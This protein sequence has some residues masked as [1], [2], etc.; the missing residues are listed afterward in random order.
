MRLKALRQ[1]M[2]LLLHH[3]H[4]YSVLRGRHFRGWPESWT[5][6]DLSMNPLLTGC[7]HPDDM[8]PQLA[9]KYFGTQVAVARWCGRDAGT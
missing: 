4:V 1:M 9:L 7:L 5:R 3:N 6:L 2:Q 8:P